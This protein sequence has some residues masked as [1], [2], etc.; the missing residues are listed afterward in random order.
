MRFKKKFFLF[1]LC[2]ILG[3]TLF[4]YFFWRAGPKETIQLVFLFSGWQ[5]L[6]LFLISAINFWIFVKKW[7][8][9]SYSYNYQ[10]PF[11]RLVPIF[12]SEMAISYLTPIMYV[13]GEGVKAYLLEKNEKKPFIKTLG[14]IAVDKLGEGIVLWL[15]LL[16]GGIIF[17]FQKIYFLGFFL[18]S[19]AFGLLI[20]LFIIFKFKGFFPLLLKIFNLIKIFQF[21]ELEQKPTAQTKEEKIQELSQTVKDLLSR[22]KK[23]FIVNFGLSFVYR[24][25]SMG[26]IY[27]MLF[28]W[29]YKLS[30]IQIYLIKIMTTL[31]GLVPTPG[32]LGGFE[33]INV[34]IFDSFNLSAPLAMA[35][36][37]VWRFF[38][39]IFV[40]AGI[41]FIVSFGLK[42]IFRWL[43]K[44]S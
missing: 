15:L 13:G 27:L 30:F 2:V 9:L 35:F 32:A 23:Y 39:L 31:A 11:F 7:Q 25:V 4:L 42:F 1:S 22:Y 37:S 28:F 44:N 17:I 43:F 10:I 20:L 8:V 16:S 14:L 6:L 40:G 21:K 19:F 29:G 34:F 33:G 5:F 12:L 18:I 24:V 36:S 41:F 3:L 38:Q 26:Q